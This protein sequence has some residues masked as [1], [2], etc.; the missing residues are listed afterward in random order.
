MNI[1]ELLKDGK[2]LGAELIDAEKL[3]EQLLTWQTLL[4]LHESYHLVEDQWEEIVKAV[5]AVILDL[6]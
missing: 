2:A 3:L 1:A 4:K 6:E 5:K